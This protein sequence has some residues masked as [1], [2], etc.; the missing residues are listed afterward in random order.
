M[1]SELLILKARRKAIEDEIESLTKSIE[2]LT[3]ESNRQENLLEEIE[4][5]INIIE[6]ERENREYERSRI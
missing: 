2:I 3:E 4:A 1:S 6:R 5:E